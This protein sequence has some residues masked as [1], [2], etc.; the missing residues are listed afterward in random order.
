MTEKDLDAY[1]ESG[2]A[3]EKAIIDGSVKIMVKLDYVNEVKI[4]LPYKGKTYSVEVNK[5][6]L[7]KFTD[8]D[9]SKIKDNLENNFSNLFVYNDKGRN[10]FLKKFGK[11]E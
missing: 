3:I 8:S 5:I 10:T 6:E 1:W 9:F 11:I 4:V 2:N 7:E